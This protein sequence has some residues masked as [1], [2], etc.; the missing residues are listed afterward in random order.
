MKSLVRCVR[1]P[2]A[3]LRGQAQLHPEGGGRQHAPG[4]GLP[5][6]RALQGRHHR[7]RERGGR[8]RAAAVRPAGVL[9]GAR[10]GR[11]RRRAGEGGVGE[12]PRRRQQH[13]EVRTT[14]SNREKSK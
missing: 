8:G 4:P 13:R 2:A 5:P 11:R 10:R 12:G 3:E 14:K 7:A 1:P 6:P 9:R